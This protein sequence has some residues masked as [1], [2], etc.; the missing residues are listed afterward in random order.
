M[1]R[2]H[3]RFSHVSSNNRLTAA[4]LK[5]CS[6]FVSMP[7]NETSKSMDRRAIWA[8]AIAQPRRGGRDAQGLTPRDPTRESPTR[9]N[10]S[11][12]TPP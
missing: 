11:H 7:F 2:S 8:Y 1:V 3:Y 5:D 12:P 9:E 6:N 10:K 4:S